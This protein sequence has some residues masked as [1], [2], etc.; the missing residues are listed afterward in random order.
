MFAPGAGGPSGLLSNVT[1]PEGDEG[2]SHEDDDIL[3]IE[4]PLHARCAE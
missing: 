3:S 1:V 2:E 4:V